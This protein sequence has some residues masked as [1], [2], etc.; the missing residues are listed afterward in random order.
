MR[1]KPSAPGAE[2]FGL[3]ERNEAVVRHGTSYVPLIRR[4]SL[5]LALYNAHKAL[6]ALFHR[7]Q[8]R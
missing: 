5:M 6:K 3:D 8:R 7:P 2:I 1:L 4:G